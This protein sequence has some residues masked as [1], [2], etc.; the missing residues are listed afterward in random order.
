[1]KQ[2]TAIKI[3]CTLLAFLFAYAAVSKLLDYNTF[4]V[5]LSQSPYITGFANVI[6]LALPVVELTVAV[7]FVFSNLRLYAFYTALFLLSLFTAYLVA[8]LNFSYYIPCSC[9]GLLSSLSWSQHIVF[10]IVFMILS[11]TGIRLSVIEKV[12][13]KYIAL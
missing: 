6:A 11:L 5:Q 8:M 2:D 7:S 10:N 13:K 9:G 1:M 12:P 4:R 3:I